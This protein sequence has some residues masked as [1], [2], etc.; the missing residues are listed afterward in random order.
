MHAS[1]PVLFVRA[2]CE[3]IE[4]LKKTLGPPASKPDSESAIQE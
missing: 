4:E 1:M 2:P 3:R